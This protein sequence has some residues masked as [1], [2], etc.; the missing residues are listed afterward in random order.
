MPGQP[1][2]V[3]MMSDAVHESEFA[4]ELLEQHVRATEFIDENRD[5]TARIVEDGIG[6]SEEV[7]R[8]ALDGPISNFVTDP[9]EIESGTETFASF[10]HEMGPID[11]EIA[12][13]DGPIYHLG[14][15]SLSNPIELLYGATA[16]LLSGRQ[17]AAIFTGSRHDPLESWDLDTASSLLDSGTVTRTFITPKQ[18]DTIK[19]LAM[20]DGEAVVVAEPAADPI[21]LPKR[22]L[23]S[24]NIRCRNPATDVLSRSVS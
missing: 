2:A 4:V 20:Q 6:I 24:R 1:G 3:V 10:S 16:A 7:A 11:K 14:S 21:D 19:H 15:L 17:Y 18:H 22:P 8:L 13:T 5:E 23:R 9:R 12:A